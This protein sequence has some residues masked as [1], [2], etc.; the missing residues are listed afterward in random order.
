MSPNNRKGTDPQVEPQKSAEDQMMVRA[1]WMYYEEELTQKGIADRLGVSRIK[2]N[3]LIKKAREK[4][5]VQISIQSSYVDYLK[6]ENELRN[7]FKLTD[8]IVTS[9]AKEGEP[10]YRVLAKAAADLFSQRL[11]AGMVVG[12]GLGKTTSLINDFITPTEAIDCTFM[13]LTGGVFDE[14]SN[15]DV[16]T[17]LHRLA[18]QFKGKAKYILAPLASSTE[19]I[20]GAILSDEKINE[21]LNLARECDMAI[22]SIGPFD[23]P[24]LLYEFGYLSDKDLKELR[25]KAAIGDA[26][27]RFFDKNGKKVSTEFDKRIIGLDFE[28]L[29]NIPTTV[30]VAGG[31]SKYLPILGVLRSQI[32]DVLVTDFQTANWLLT[33]VPPD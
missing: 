3:R 18:E 13:P 15:Q 11:T 4:G 6:I 28:D 7:R 22:F 29:R 19:E 25:N 33:Q 2:V 5:I 1:A 8:V 17:V 14:D 21:S 9:E 24:G 23:P 26:I 27:G 10:L 31:K 32:A 12:I 30:V 20:K 16:Q